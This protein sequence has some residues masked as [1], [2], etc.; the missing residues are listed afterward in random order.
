[1]ALSG[2]RLTAFVETAPAEDADMPWWLAEAK[3]HVHPAISKPVET[4]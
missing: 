2:A 3:T 4:N 1:M